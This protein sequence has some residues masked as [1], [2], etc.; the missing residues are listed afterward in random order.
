MLSLWGQRFYNTPLW[1]FA[2]LSR[3][4]TP[5]GPVLVNLPL[6]SASLPREPQHPSGGIDIC[7]FKP[8]LLVSTRFTRPS[9][10]KHLGAT[11]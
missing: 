7:P 8:E 10:V 4:P 1:S 3:H 6:D 2:L 11:F 9:V 5:P